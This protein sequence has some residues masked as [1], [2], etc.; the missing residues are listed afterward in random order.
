MPLKMHQDEMPQINL[1]PMVDIIF[2]LII[3]FMVGSRFT[4]M[5]KKVDVSVPQVANAAQLPTAPTRYVVNVHRD[6]NITFNN[7]PVTLQSLTQE[8]KT[9][10]QTKTDLN[11]VVR[12]DADGPLQNVAAVLTACRQA[13]V[14]DV[15]IS[16]RGGVKER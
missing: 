5:D 9:A 13:G 8:L 4:E 6:G 16:V 2:Q 15:G 3:F 1:T 11:V 12:G 7:Q 10:R 14:A